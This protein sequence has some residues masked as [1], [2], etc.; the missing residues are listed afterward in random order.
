MGRLALIADELDE[1]ATAARIRSRMKPELEKWFS[2][3]NSNPLVYDNTWGGIVSLNSLKNVGANFGNA[4]YNDHHYHYGYFVY[5]AAV[6]GKEDPQWLQDNLGAVLDL[7]RD[8]ANPNKE[9]AHFVFTRHKD[10]YAWHSW[11]GG[12]FS[13]A[14][15]KNQESTSEAVNGYYAVHLLGLALNDPRISNFGR[16]LMQMEIRSSRKYW[17]VSHFP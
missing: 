1:S 11:A 16:I 8:Y 7:V 17:Q 4:A 12:L 9:D 15:A 10:L 6:V 13:A 3:S 14:D 2:S 5:A